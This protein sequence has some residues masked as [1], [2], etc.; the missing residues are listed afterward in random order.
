[1]KTKEKEEG[2]I[3]RE[4][5]WE[6]PRAVAFCYTKGI[7]PPLPGAKAQAKSLSRVFLPFPPIEFLKAFH[8]KRGPFDFPTPN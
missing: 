6:T 4:A 3:N 8:E 5:W 2:V 7:F 1:M